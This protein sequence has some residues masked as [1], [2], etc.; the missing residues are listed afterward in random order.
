MDVPIYSASSSENVSDEDNVFGFGA[1]DVYPEKFDPTEENES[2][3]DA[4]ELE[5]ERYIYASDERLENYSVYTRRV[6]T[7]KQLKNETI[8]IMLEQSNFFL[9]QIQIGYIL[10]DI[11]TLEYHLFYAA[12]NTGIFPVAIAVKKKSDMNKVM[13]AIEKF[14]FENFFNTVKSGQ[15]V[16]RLS[17]ARFLINTD[18]RPLST[19]DCVY[20]TMP[21]Y[22]KNNPFII[23]KN[24]IIKTHSSCDNLCMIR[25]LAEHMVRTK[26]SVFIGGRTKIVKTIF[27]MFMR[28]L[29]TSYIKPRYFNGVS[30]DQVPILEK[31]CLTQINIYIFERVGAVSYKYPKQLKATPIY[32]SKMGETEAINGVCHL[33][34]WN[35]HVCYISNLYKVRHFFS[36]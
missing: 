6:Q 19:C 28:K 12:Y 24:E 18:S 21:L 25:A 22:L 10:K 35:T 27:Q 11:S 31:M 17:Y 2:A 3:I 14:G 5:S 20:E 33:V 34:R 23:T 29:G 9:I 4:V 7:L 26:N 1:N 15:T 13:K 36:S 30:M 8:S 16:V 32:L